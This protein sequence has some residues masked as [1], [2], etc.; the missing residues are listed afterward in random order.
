MKFNTK[1][2]NGKK[3][4]RTKKII[5]KTRKTNRKNN[6]KIL[7]GEDNIK[8]GNFETK[9]GTITRKYTGQYKDEGEKKIYNGI[10]KEDFISTILDSYYIGNFVDGKKSE[11]GIFV[12]QE[13][14]K[15]NKKI[16]NDEFYICN[17]VNDNP[18]GLGIEIQRI[19]EDY[20]D[21]TTGEIYENQNIISFYHFENLNNKKKLKDIQFGKEIGIITYYYEEKPLVD[22]QQNMN[23]VFYK[24]KKDQIDG[25]INTRIDFLKNEIE[26]LKTNMQELE[27]NNTN[28]K[29]YKDNEGNLIDK[30]ERY[31]KIIEEKVQKNQYKP[32]E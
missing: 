32:N 2:N 7:G 20:K 25:Q 1:K 19:V 28:T 5:R 27:N 23:N 8:F 21:P 4:K 14:D 18:I 31:I 3:A 11:F 29:F 16:K 24:I 26:T 10:G 15:N 17:F 22:N 9:I 6:K 30:A 13:M 12:S